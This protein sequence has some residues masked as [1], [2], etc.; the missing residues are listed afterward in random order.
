M[1]IERNFY[2]HQ[3]KF[4]GVYE[5]CFS[6]HYYWEYKPLTALSD[7]P[8]LPNVYVDDGDGFTLVFIEEHLN[9]NNTQNS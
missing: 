3:G 9:E 7:P 4:C 8:D 6:N 5:L 2:N 1:R